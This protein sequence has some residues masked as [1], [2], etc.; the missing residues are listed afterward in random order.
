MNIRI[1]SQKPQLM[2]PVDDIEK[3]GTRKRI[4]RQGVL[5]V[6]SREPSRRREE[7]QGTSEPRRTNSRLEWDFTL[8][9]EQQEPELG[10]EEAGLVEEVEEFIQDIGAT[11]EVV[12]GGE[13][14]KNR[15]ETGWRESSSERMAQP[16]PLPS[17]VLH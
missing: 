14:L 6:D 10:C 8:V 16:P 17:N 5:K 3:I 15:V 4:G 9:T 1:R 2:P 7:T 12:D 13:I 11:F